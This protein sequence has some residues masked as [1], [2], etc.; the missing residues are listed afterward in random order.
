MAGEPEHVVAGMLAVTTSGLSKMLSVAGDGQRI[1]W[2]DAFERTF[3]TLFDLFIW[4]L[5][6][7]TVALGKALG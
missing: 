2:G 3:R 5:D 7:L 4:A 6:T 1:D